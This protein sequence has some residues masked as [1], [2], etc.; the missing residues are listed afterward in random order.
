MKGRWRLVYKDYVS[1]FHELLEED[2]SVTIHKCNLRALFIEM[3]KINHKIS[4]T[5]I[6]E[7]VVKGDPAYNT[8]SIANVVLD[9]NNRAEISKNLPI[10]FKKST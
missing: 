8:R 5:F 6:T 7:L 10:S 9:A 2:K 3:Y 1:N 4:P